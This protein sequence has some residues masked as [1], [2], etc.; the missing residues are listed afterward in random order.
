MITHVVLIKLRD[1]ETGPDLRDRL[2]A[3][4]VQIPQIRSYQVGLDVVHGPRSYD[5]ALVSAFDSLE[6]LQA[7]ID[8]PAH[9]AV[10]TFLN[11][12]SETRVSC[13]YH[14]ENM[15]S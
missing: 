4:A 10:V 5:V 8:H 7:Y 9:Q 12:V 1:P 13:D 14:D 15:R 11:Q 3:L 6:D 2:L